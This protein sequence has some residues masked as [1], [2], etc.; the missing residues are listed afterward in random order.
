M[1]IISSEKFRTT[2]IVFI[3]FS[4][5]TVLVTMLVAS[6]NFSITHTRDNFVI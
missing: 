5:A 2:V 4:F 6:N 3:Y 1:K